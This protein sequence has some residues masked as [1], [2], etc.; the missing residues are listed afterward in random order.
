ME[1]TSLPESKD[2]KAGTRLKELS[3][4]HIWL[5]VLKTILLS[6]G[7][8]TLFCWSTLDKTVITVPPPSGL[9]LTVV[10]RGPNRSE[11]LIWS[12][13]I[14]GCPLKT[15]TECSSNAFWISTKSLFESS[16][17]CTSQSISAPICSVIFLMEIAIE[18]FAKLFKNL[19]HL[20]RISA[21][22]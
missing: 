15:S 21:L 3:V 10:S 7:G 13:S 1:G 19:Y 4:C 14:R 18:T 5:P 11:K 12:S 20:K 22:T 16:R 2:I 8:I 17:R 6:S 9:E